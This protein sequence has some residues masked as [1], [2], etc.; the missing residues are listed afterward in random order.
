MM[1]G[2]RCSCRSWPANRQSVEARQHPVEDDQLGRL[3]PHEVQSG[4]SVVRQAH[5][6]AFG[7]Q[8]GADQVAQACLVFDHQ[9]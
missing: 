3:Q 6:M 7:L 5:D 4:W 1:I 8:L 2:I 9:D